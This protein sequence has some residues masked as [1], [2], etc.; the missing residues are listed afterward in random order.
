MG[1]EG[2][3]AVCGGRG[4]GAGGAVG[5]EEGGVGVGGGRGVDGAGAAGVEGEEVLSGCV[6]AGDY[7]EVGAGGGA[8]EGAG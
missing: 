1:L 2:A 3:A 4:C 8:G 7:V 5:G 6:D